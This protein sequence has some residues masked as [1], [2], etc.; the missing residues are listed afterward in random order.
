MQW[1]KISLFP[2]KQSINTYYCSIYI[3]CKCKRNTISTPRIHVIS[4]D[5]ILLLHFPATFVI[6][7]DLNRYAWYSVLFFA[8]FKSLSGGRDRPRE[9]RRF[10]WGPV[11]LQKKLEAETERGGRW[12]GSG[13]E[14]EARQSHTPSA[15]P[16]A[17]SSG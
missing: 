2:P 1:L 14:S 5:S 16:N 4:T 9:S 13:N 17:S 8:L 6:V 10:C 12:A 11:V 15:S 7:I 3:Y